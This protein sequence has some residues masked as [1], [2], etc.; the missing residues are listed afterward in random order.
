MVETP[1]YE[2]LQR[3]IQTLENELDAQKK[4][5]ESLIEN[6]KKYWN[7][8]E[9]MEEGYFE[10]DLKG[11]LTFFNDVIVQF[12]QRPRDELLG[13][14]YR[15]FTTQATAEKVYKTYN[16]IYRTGIPAI[17]S[18]CEAVKKDGSIGVV[19]VTVSLVKDP[20]GEPIGFCGVSR[21]VTEKKKAEKA[22]CES[23]ERY[24]QILE[25][26][27]EGYY[28]V[29]LAG[30]FIFCNE[31]LCRIH[32]YPCNELLTMN[33]RD[34]TS[35]EEA[36]RV[37]KIFNQ[38][39]QTGIPSKIVDLEIFGK[40]G[41]THMIE[42]SASLQ[43]NDMGIPIGFYGITRD[44]TE[45][46]KAEEALRQ[47]EERYRNILESIE[48]GYYEVD[49]TGHITFFNETI[50]TFH[51]R[52][53]DELRGLC[54]QD[55]I[56][57][58]DHQKVFKIFN[59][60]YKTGMPAEI[61]ETRM[62]RKDGQLRNVEISVSLLCN[63]KR[64]PIG[65]R[66][67]TRDR[68]EQKKIEKALKESEEKY[69]LVVENA[70]E[71]IYII[72]D[73][74]IKFPNPRMNELTG[75][76]ME[77]LKDIPLLD[78]VH[79]DDRDKIEQQI[80]QSFKD[81]APLNIYSF[82]MLNKAGSIIWVDLNTIPIMWEG[83]PA[84]LNFLRDIT[85]HKKMEL[86]LLQASKM[87]ALGTLAGGVA[88]NFNNLLMGIQGNASLIQLDVDREHPHY[89]KLNNIT[90]LVKDGSMLAKQLLGAARGGKYEVRTTDVNRLLEQSVYLFG[91]TKKEITIHKDLQVDI[92]P[93]EVDSGQIDQVL[94]NLYINAW[95][96]MSGGGDL[97]VQTQNVI[98]ND[99]YTSPY[100]V[101]PGRFV[102]ISI[103]D[104]GIGMDE[105]TVGKIFDPFFTT[106]DMVVGTG[107][108]LAS[109]YGIIQNHKGFIT[110]YSQKG[111]GTT[112]NIYLP[113]TE[114]KVVEERAVQDEILTG[115]GTILFVDDEDGVRQIGKAIL[116]RLGYQV[117]IA[118]S[119]EKALEIFQKDKDKIDMI[120][121][122]MIMPDM[123]GG[124]TFDQLKKID[125]NVKVLLS[126]GYTLNGEAKAI[127]DRGCKGFI[128]KPF[129]LSE[130]SK[131]VKQIKG[132]NE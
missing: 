62:I 83:R 36:K 80:R 74:M 101:A 97:Y 105:S 16:E 47:S 132:E 88:H 13:M 127:L 2:D 20:L 56:P 19:E 49:P 109:A 99:D 42:I 107:L 61:F 50:C 10:C 81:Q 111:S 24:R 100:H 129:S 104:T 14:N 110:V 77:E 113:A 26:M 73:D 87:E 85:P 82:K 7:I 27:E 103:T 33:N 11:N 79:Q 17:L 44:R 40:D 119:G 90:K 30:N 91:R 53:P 114:K 126:S 78:L 28:E 66:G 124:E 45:Q 51:G 115:S 22:L 3:R 117:L 23:E 37:Y 35:P 52:S 38:V 43:R 1:T 86:Q 67:I 98:L 121:L 15:E 70:N 75:Y 8:L 31:A 18:D 68:T 54:Y 4:I 130:L 29:N 123:S 65:F 25:K 112:F 69:R 6:E 9:I 128:Q 131:R 58:D 84:T 94:F 46:K 55:F 120:I 5:K 41:S 125:P 118:K 48:E 59:D 63:E 12:Y 96:A 64:E 21:D 76:S 92:W 34:Y 71:G 116:T 57:S 32:G 93:V 60:V 39:Y 122:D 102:K 95:H 89:E 106:K 72:Q 108:G